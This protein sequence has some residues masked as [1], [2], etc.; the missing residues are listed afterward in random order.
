ML[1][2]EDKQN[3]YKFIAACIGDDHSIKQYQP[4]FNDHT[5]AVVEEMVNEN[6]KC[7][8]RMKEL[9]KGLIGGA[10]H[11]TKGWLKKLLKTAKK[12]LAEIQLNGLGC[13]VIVKSRWKSAIMVS[14]I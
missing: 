10:A 8:A 6:I 12:E 9:L 1:S 13:L 2:S 5:I 11:L 3:L 7:N 14:T 4:L